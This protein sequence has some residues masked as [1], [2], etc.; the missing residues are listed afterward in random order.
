[1]SEP[2]FRFP[3]ADE[4]PEGV[5]VTTLGYENRCLI[6]GHITLGATPG[7]TVLSPVCV[8]GASGAL[9]RVAIGRTPDVTPEEALRALAAATRAYAGGR[10]EWPSMP[11][12]GRIGALEG[13]VERMV[14]VRE[15]VVRLLMWEIA[16]T[17]KDAESEFDRTVVYIR[18]TLEALKEQDRTAARFALEE[19]FIGQFRRSPLGVALC[20]GP[21]NYP[22]NETFATLIPALVMGNTVVSKLPK[23]GQLV[24]LPLLPAFAESFPPGVVNIIQGQGAKVIGP[25]ME[26]GQVDVLAFIGSAS[27]ANLLKKQH[28]R[29]N[30][31]RCIL[32]LGAKNP[33]VILPDADLEAAVAEC[34]SGALSYN[35]QRCT[36][37]KLLM[38]HQRIAEDFARRVATAVDALPAGLPWDS[39][40]KLTPLPEDGKPAAMAALVEDAVGKGARILNQGGW[41][42]GTFFRPAVV[43]PVTPEMR[44]YHEEQFGPIVPIAPFRSESEAVAAIEASPYGQQVAIFGQDPPTVARWIDA[45]V[46][47]VSRINL[48]T[49]CRRGPDTFP[50]T[51]R[52]DSAEGTLSVS[53]ALRCFSIRTVVATTAHDA[54]QRLV[55]DIVTRRLSSFLST[56]FLF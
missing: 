40:V 15:E 21:Y 16:K 51:G 53:D 2:R 54:N 14:G 48:N 33:A 11:V 34:V 20:M 49:Q 31:L 18:D 4:I 1:M 43:Y 23:C 38:P 44:L 9:E 46:R 42:E 13:F 37:L 26:S 22:L 45:L 6:D 50:F 41:S 36:A 25:I 29:P 52:K 3:T 27:V 8:R 28:P 35:G 32:G 47:T 30:R 17:R 55:S 39:G 56:D 7:T 12:A 24:H 10:G 5:R 19:G